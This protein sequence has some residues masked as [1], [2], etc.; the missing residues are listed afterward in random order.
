VSP[1]DYAIGHPDSTVLANDTITSVR[2]SRQRTKFGDKY[3]VLTVGQEAHT[4]T[5]FNIAPQRN[6]ALRNSSQLGALFASVFGDRFTND[7]VE[8]PRAPLK[9]HTYRALL[10]ATGLGFGITAVACF[11]PW[12]S[13]R[14]VPT[15]AA[16]G[17]SPYTVTS[18]VA[19]LGPAILI[20][21]GIG[22]VLFAIGQLAKPRINWTLRVSV[23][24]TAVVAIELLRS[25]LLMSDDARQ[26]SNATV[27]VSASPAV[28]LYL[29]FLGTAIAAATQAILMYRTN[30]ER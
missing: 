19:D 29:A 24:V 4:E 13:A 17:E 5:R 6:P 12:I 2:L 15:G 16:L 21:L 23:S 26:A 28:G 18:T 14:Y 22:V 11:R 25:A 27:H 9:S 1:A 20:S 30:R 7:A 10:L 8:A 3:F